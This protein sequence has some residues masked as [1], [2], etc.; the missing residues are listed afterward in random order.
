MTD[1]VAV[2]DGLVAVG[3]F[4]TVQF[5]T[6]TS[7]ISPDGRS[8]RR[9]SPDAVL[10][11]GEMLAVARGGPRLVAVGSFGAPDNYIPTIWLSE[12]ASGG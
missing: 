8:W 7:W 6:A 4:V 10:Q 5:G 11:Q 9:A 3:N 2:P 1:V 12:L